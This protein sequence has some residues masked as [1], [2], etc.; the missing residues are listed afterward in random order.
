MIYVTN[1]KNSKLTKEKKVDCT[2]API[3]QT[4]PNSCSMKKDNLC[5]A[6]IGFV[7]IHNQRAIKKAK[8]LSKVEIAKFEAKEIL[9]NINTQSKLLR[10]H[11]SGD[12]ET[13]TGTKILSKAS[14]KWI[15]NTN[16]RVWTYTHAW[17]NVP[18]SYWG[19]VSVL[20][21]VDS[22]D[23]IPKARKMGYAPAIIV[24]KF[25][26][27]KAFKIGNTKYIPCPS[28][29]RDVSCSDCN[30]CMNADR[31]FKDNFGIAFAAHG[32]TKEKIKK[33]LKII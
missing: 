20:A 13:K 23:D 22:L 28:Q 19:K 5:Y 4:C 9:K 24:D 17:K 21:S 26:S 25:E 14:E 1:S 30:L 10:L 3:E 31:L 33:R 15:D 29:T 12:S 27:D 6:A 18:R 2:Y 8:K 32:A 7:G 11:V 16:G